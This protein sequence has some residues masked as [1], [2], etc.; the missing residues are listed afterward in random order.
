MGVRGGNPEPDTKEN[1]LQAKSPDPK[2][3][4]FWDP[5]G[6]KAAQRVPC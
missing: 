6:P 4:L 2:R 1:G 5:V 3:K